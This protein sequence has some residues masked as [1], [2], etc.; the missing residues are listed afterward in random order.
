M[1]V[2]IWN[3]G[4]LNDFDPVLIDEIDHRILHLISKIRVVRDHVSSWNQSGT[5]RIEI[6]CG[7]I[8]PGHS[9]CL[10]ERLLLHDR[11]R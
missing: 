8:Q 3:A 2:R 9:S 11:S 7:F 1:P 4:T 5:R 10:A 6:H